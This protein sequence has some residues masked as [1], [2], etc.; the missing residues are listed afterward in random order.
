VK[1]QH[2]WVTV[3]PNERDD[4]NKLEQMGN[5]G[6]ELVSVIPWGYSAEYSGAAGISRPNYF[7]MFFKRPKGE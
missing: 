4:I 1:W 3:N 7:V 5:E 6:W 2:A